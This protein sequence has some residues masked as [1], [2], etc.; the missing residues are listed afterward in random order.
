MLPPGHVYIPAL[1]SSHRCI[2]LD[3]YAKDCMRDKDILSDL[4]TDVILSTG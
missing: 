3:P 1:P 2:N 4:L